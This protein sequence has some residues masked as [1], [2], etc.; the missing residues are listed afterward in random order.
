MEVC[1]VILLELNSRRFLTFIRNNTAELFEEI[2]IFLFIIFIN[3]LRLIIFFL[4]FLIDFDLNFPSNKLLECDFFN[5]V[6]NLLF[7]MIHF[8]IEHESKYIS[9]SLNKLQMQRIFSIEAYGYRS[10][11]ETRPE[12]FSGFLDDMILRKRMKKLHYLDVE[13]ILEYIGA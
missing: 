6:F 12:W 4:I 5:H 2:L 1:R 8:D 7:V 11:L 9:S 3:L 10:S 13:D